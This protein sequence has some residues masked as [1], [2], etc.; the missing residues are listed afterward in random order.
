[1]VKTRRATRSPRVGRTVRD[2]EIRLATDE[3]DSGFTRG[4]DH[5][6]SGVRSQKLAQDREHHHVGHVGRTG[7]AHGPGH[8]ALEAV[9]SVGER[10]DGGLGL[11][12]RDEKVFGGLGGRQPVAAAVEEGGVEGVFE[13]GEPAG[14]GGDVDAQGLGSLSHGS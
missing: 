13:G 9:H 7:D 12:G 14:D 5:P 1:M 6:Q 2:R 3:I 8:V 4:E 10:G 11:L